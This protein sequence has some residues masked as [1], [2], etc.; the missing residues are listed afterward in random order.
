MGMPEASIEIELKGARSTSVVIKREIKK[1]TKESTWYLNGRRV[2][3][4][5]SP[6][7]PGGGHRQMYPRALLICIFFYTV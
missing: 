6:T 3:N 5:L 2:Q 7:C 4:P 1:A